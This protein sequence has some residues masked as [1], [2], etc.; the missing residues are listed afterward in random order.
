MDDFLID[1]WSFFVESHIED[2]GDIIDDIHLVLAEDD[3][4]SIVVRAHS[5]PYV[6][7]QHY[8]SSQVDVIVD[9]YVQ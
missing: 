2:L 8:K 5:N 3:A 9:P 6:Y 7:S 1:I 4:S